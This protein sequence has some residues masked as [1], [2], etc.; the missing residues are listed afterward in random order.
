L[1]NK[2]KISKL[3]NRNELFFTSVVTILILSF[4]IGFIHESGHILVCVSNDYDYTFTFED[5][6]MNVYCSN[7]PQPVLLYFA[8]GGTF[9]VIASMMLFLLKIVRTNKGIFMGVS[10]TAFDHFLKAIFETFTHSDY[11][12]NTNLFIYMSVLPILLLFMLWW[13]FTKQPQKKLKSN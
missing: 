8:L 10:V 12:F 5:L 11:L 1:N 7:T 9:G 4:P 13:Y 2:N 3:W 6:A